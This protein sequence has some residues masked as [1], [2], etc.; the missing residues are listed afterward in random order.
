[1]SITT[2]AE[3]QTVIADFLDRDDQTE[4]IKTFIDLAEANMDRKLRHFRMEK[5]STATVSA[6]YLTLPTDF[7]EPIRFMMTGGSKT[8]H[9]ELMGQGQ[10]AQLR[11]QT[12]DSSGQPT[13]Y[14]ITDGSIE[15]FPRPDGDYTIELVYYAKIDKLT[16]GNTSNWVLEYHPDLYLYGALIHSAP[17][18]GEDARMGTWAA[19]YQGA[20]DAIT[21][22]SDNAKSGGAGRRIKIRS[23]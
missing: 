12:A 5:R 10:I 1:M 7:L 3:L 6:Q 22:E 13:N 18:L 21:L 20:L 15:L 9:L 17:F 11:E 23:Y 14:V 8:K 19:L 4:R 2:Y 16:T